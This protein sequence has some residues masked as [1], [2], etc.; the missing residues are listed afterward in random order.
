MASIDKIKI[1]T[2]SYDISPSKN[3]T[4]IGFNSGDDV[5]PPHWMG[6]CKCNF[7]IRFK[8]YHFQ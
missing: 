4:L 8:Q 5:T 6:K 2:T 7:R 3:G 1:D